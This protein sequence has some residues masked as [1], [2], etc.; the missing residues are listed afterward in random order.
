M[1]GQLDPLHGLKENV[2]IG[3]LV[4]AG[5]GSSAF[6]PPVSSDENDEEPQTEM[7]MQPEPLD[8]G[9]EADPSVK[10]ASPV[11]EA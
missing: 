11:P 2:I 7:G 9:E 1:K 10:A 8:G 6:H 4:P 3:H 5:T